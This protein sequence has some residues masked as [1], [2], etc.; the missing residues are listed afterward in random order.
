MSARHTTPC[1]ERVAN[2]PADDDRRWQ[3]CGLVAARPEWPRPSP[4]PHEILRDRQRIST[5]DPGKEALGRRGA[6]LRCR[7]VNATK[8]P[9]PPAHTIATHDP[10]SLIQRQALRAP[11]VI[12]DADGRRFGLLL[13]TAAL[14][15][16]PSCCCAMIGPS[17]QRATRRKPEFCAS[18]AFRLYADPCYHPV[19]DPQ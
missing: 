9:L 19:E 12:W 2:F 10:L 5:C 13:K 18:T 7:L 11:A 1:R 14:S 8:G 6:V 15:P 4:M 3:R 16:G 17:A